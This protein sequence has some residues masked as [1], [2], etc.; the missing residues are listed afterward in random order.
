MACKSIYPQI[1]S[2]AQRSTAAKVY[3][4]N[5]PTQK[6][7]EFFEAK[8]LLALKQEDQREQW[9]ADWLSYQATH[10]LY[11][12]VLK[13]QQDADGGFGLNVLNYARF[14]EVFAYYSPAHGYSLQVTSLGLFSILLGTN[15]EL[16]QE[17]LAALEQ[18]DLLAFGVSEKDHGSD[19]LANGFT[20]R[21]LGAGRFLAH[22]KKYYIGNA[23]AASIISTLAHEEDGRTNGSARRSVPILFALR[24]K[25][26]K[27]FAVKKIRTLGV[28]GAFVGD[29]EVKDH[30]FPASDMIARGRDAWDAVFGAVT[31]GK[32]FLNFGSIGIC[33]HALAEA[34]EHLSQRVLY[35]KPAIEMPHLRIAM[36]QAYARLTAMKL[37]AYRALDYVNSASAHDRRYVLYC[38]VQKAKVS[39]EGVKVM[40]QLSECIGAKGFEAET[41][42]EMALRDVQLFPGLEGSTHIN[43]A[44]T[45]QFIPCYFDRVDPKIVNPK[46]LAN[47]PQASGGNPYLFGARSGGINTIAFPDHLKSYAPLMAIPNVRLFAKQAKAFEL[48]ARKHAAESAPEKNMQVNLLLGQGLAM[49]T[50]GQLIAENAVHFEVP[51]QMVSTIFH[52]LVNDLTS[53]MIAVISSGQFDAAA[54]KLLERR[55]VAVPK[56]AA[57]D[58]D[59]LAIR[60]QKFEPR[61]NT[62]EHR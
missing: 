35:G 53:A 3:F 49:I 52:L 8:G 55:G 58:W 4:A 2:A 59:F 22:G 5:S 47:T 16:K 21:D 20:I 10:G 24:P 56:T 43:L 34:S 40:A 45:A 23:N 17:A 46:S 50:Y 37:Y 1:F 62:D 27:N 9:C 42:F 51:A 32:F 25:Q 14:L 7:A 13:P 54:M 48:F 18:G 28:R 36:A 26:S 6:L 15:P 44:M 11:A 39:T 31:L 60:M 19:L 12:A 41:Y 57:A 38:A 61:M 30:E 29:F 33:E